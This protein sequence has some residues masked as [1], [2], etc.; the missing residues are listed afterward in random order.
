LEFSAEPTNTA[1][2]TNSAFESRPAARLDAIDC[3]RTIANEAA[4][5]L[6]ALGLPVPHDTITRVRRLHANGNPDDT[7]H[8]IRAWWITARLATG[9]DD[10]PWKPDNTCPSC[11]G[12]GTIRIRLAD[13]IARCTTCH[14]TWDPSTIGILA[15][16][17]RTE[18]AAHSPRID[19][20]PCYCPLPKPEIHD[21]RHQCQRCG[22]ARCHRA[23]AERALDDLRKET[24]DI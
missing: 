20:T 18:N 11:N 2:G 13:R 5:H 12:R 6:T 24:L 1:A 3:M 21:L 10:P 15:E 22:S 4:D 8:I 19:L 7:D 16:H 14:A 17:I 9:W 23:V